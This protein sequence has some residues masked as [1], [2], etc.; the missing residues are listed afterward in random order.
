MRYWGIEEA[1]K[2]LSNALPSQFDSDGFVVVH[3]E[4]RTNQDVPEAVAVLIRPEL[5][6][7]YQE[8]ARWYLLKEA[9]GDKDFRR[10]AM[11]LAPALE[12]AARWAVPLDRFHES[13]IAKLLFARITE[14]QAKDLRELPQLSD[15][16]YAAFAA[17]IAEVLHERKSPN[18]SRP[19]VSLEP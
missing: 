15:E 6:R 9:G 2:K 13:A 16:D 18:W 12:H 3:D 8:I 7:Q 10:E 1:R 14:Q 11:E 17:S 19:P 4:K 5:F